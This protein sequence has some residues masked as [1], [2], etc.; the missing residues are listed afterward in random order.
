MQ[1]MN[2]IILRGE[3]YG[4][5]IEDSNNNVTIVI[6][7]DFENVEYIPLKK[8]EVIAI[9]KLLEGTLKIKDIY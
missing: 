5:H 3:S 4:I 6:E 2:R 1:K 7:N 8:D 9:I